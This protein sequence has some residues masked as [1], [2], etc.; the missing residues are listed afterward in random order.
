MLELSASVHFG[1]CGAFCLLSFPY[2]NEMNWGTDWKLKPC[3]LPDV[4]GKVRPQ[5]SGI[6]EIRGLG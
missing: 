6:T 1:A 5:G 4:V 3:P 2:Q